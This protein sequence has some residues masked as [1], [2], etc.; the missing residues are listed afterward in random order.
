LD[1]DGSPSLRFKTEIRLGAN[2][3]EFDMTGGLPGLCGVEHAGLTVPD[4]DAATSFFV[5]VIGCELVFAAGP[6]RS[7]ENWMAEHLNVDARAEI[8]QL[9]MLKCKNG[10]SIELFD[11]RLTGRSEA[12][13]KNTDLAGHHLAFYVEDMQAAV[14][15]LKRHNVRIMGDPTTMSDGPSAGL[16]WVYF[17]A[18]WGLQLELVSYP[19]GMAYELTTKTRL[20]RP[21]KPAE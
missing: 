13:A 8:K 11:Y 9:R 21:E 4:L 18:P 2:V 16:T 1:F 12:Q 7:D 20:W 6:F 14:A 17:L 3:K 10:P 5:D 15:H 19:K